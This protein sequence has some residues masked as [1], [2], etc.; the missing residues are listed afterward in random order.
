MNRVLFPIVAVAT[1]ALAASA[2]AQMPPPT[3]YDV[4]TMNFDLWCQ[5]TAHID[6]DRCDRRLPDDEQ[7][8]D[9][10]RGTIE[11][12]ELSHLKDKE[13]EFNIDQNLIHKDPIDEP[14]NTQ[15]SQ[16]TA[17]SKNNP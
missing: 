11:K 1:F 6:P 7:A 8:F 12:Y 2:N 14:L 5:E 13:R 9:A 4:Q 17:Q 16:P 3:T 10:Y 15:L